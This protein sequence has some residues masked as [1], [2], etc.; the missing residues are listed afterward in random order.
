MKTIFHLYRNGEWVD[1]SENKKDLDL[2]VQSSQD[3]RIEPEQVEDGA[4]VPQR[5]W[6]F[7]TPKEQQTAKNNW[8]AR[9]ANLLG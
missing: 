7:G 2:F 4:E 6:H 9:R 5:S 8:R 1:A 3:Y